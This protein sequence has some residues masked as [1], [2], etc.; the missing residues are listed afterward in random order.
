MSTQAT[1]VTLEDFRQMPPPPFGVKR[2]LIEGVVTEMGKALG[3]HEKVKSNFLDLF[4]EV[5]NR[6]SLWALVS[7][8]EFVLGETMD[9][10]PDV[11]IV[12][13]R[14][15]LAAPVDKHLS[16]PP[17]LSVEVVSSEKA[18]DLEA[19]VRGYLNHGVSTVLVA[20]PKLREIQIRT[21]NGYLELTAESRLELPQLF[22][23]WSADVSDFFLGV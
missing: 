6:K 10:I 3:G 14:D 1:L 20:Y 2:E 15:I 12:L 5:C 17:V 9:A 22:P 11:A 18:E 16:F 19:K 7:E 21:S 4:G 8:S 13:R 23:D